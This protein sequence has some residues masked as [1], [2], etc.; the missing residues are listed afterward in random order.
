MIQRTEGNKKTSTTNKNQDITKLLKE[1][2]IDN[3]ALKIKIAE[4]E[5]KVKRGN[6]NYYVLKDKY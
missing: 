4:L 5:K 3:S 2:Q 1:V 6:Q